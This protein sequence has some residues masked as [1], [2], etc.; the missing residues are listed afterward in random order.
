MASSLVAAAE[1]ASGPEVGSPI[2][3]IRTLDQHGRERTFADLRG[4]DGLLLLFY[5]TV[6][7]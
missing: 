1:F 7:W 3:E 5:R 4:P 2:P 6:D